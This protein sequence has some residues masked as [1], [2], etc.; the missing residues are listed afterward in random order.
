MRANIVA[1][2]AFRYTVEIRK[3]AVP[4]GSYSFV[5]TSTWHGAKEPT[6]EHAALQITVDAD[7]LMALR[8]LIN[9]EVRRDESRRGHGC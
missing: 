8:D 9:A 3:L 4:A 1:T 2:E 6:A 5:I 7:G